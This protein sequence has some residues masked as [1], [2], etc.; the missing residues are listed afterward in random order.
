[1]GRFIQMHLHLPFIL[2]HGYSD[3]GSEY[4]NEAPSSQ[5]VE[6]GFKSE[7]QYILGFNG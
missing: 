3:L 4:I 6:R 5:R 1:M 7:V 2:I